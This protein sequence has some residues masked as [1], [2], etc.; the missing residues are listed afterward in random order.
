MQETFIHFLSIVVTLEGEAMELD[1]Y[2]GPAWIAC[3]QAQ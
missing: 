2:W 3:F 1:I